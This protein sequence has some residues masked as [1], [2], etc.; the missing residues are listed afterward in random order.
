MWVNGEMARSSGRLGNLP[1]I[2]L[3]PRLE[4]PRSEGQTPRPDQQRELA[5]TGGPAR[6]LELAALS[7]RGRQVIVENQGATGF[8]VLCWAY[9]QVK[10]IKPLQICVLAGRSFRPGDFAASHL[11]VADA[12]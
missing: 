9:L 6:Q 7:T 12:D 10:N 11:V 5:V 1:L 2:V 4:G 3:S 8:E